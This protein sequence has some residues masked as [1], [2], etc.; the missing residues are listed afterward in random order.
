VDGDG[1][2][3]MAADMVADMAEDT[4]KVYFNPVVITPSH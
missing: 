3:D 4:V 1:P 2:E